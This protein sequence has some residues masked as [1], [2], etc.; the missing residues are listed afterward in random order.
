MLG[1]SKLDRC[2]ANAFDTL[3]EKCTVSMEIY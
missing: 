3:I 1:Y 2:K